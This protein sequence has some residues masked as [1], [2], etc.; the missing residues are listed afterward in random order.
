MEM[1]LG[2]LVDKNLNMC[3]QFVFATQNANCLL[4]CI[5]RGVGSGRRAVSVLGSTPVWSP[6]SRPGAV[7]TR[8]TWSYWNKCRGGHKADHRNRSVNNYLEIVFF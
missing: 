2:I 5:K 1:D 7:S 4:G 3:W 8:K 6:A